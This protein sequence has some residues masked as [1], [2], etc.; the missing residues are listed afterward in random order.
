MPPISSVPSSQLFSGEECQMG[1]A[2]SV[3]SRWLSEVLA[4]A[5]SA[6]WNTLA[7]LCRQPLGW[8]VVPEV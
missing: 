8:P 7:W 2:I 4:A 1:M 5:H 3:R 6:A